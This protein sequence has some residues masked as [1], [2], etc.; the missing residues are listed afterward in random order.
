MYEVEGGVAG[1]LGNMING[2][3]SEDS[4]A[5][6]AAPK[7]SAPAV[8]SGGESVDSVGSGDSGSGSSGGGVLDL[9]GTWRKDFARFTGAIGNMSRRWI[10]MA[11]HIQDQAAEIVADLYREYIR[12]GISPENTV[13]TKILSGVHPPLAGLADHIVVIKAGAR[14]LA[15]GFGHPGRVKPAVVTWDQKW[16]KV[17]FMHDVGYAIHVTPEQRNAI[18]AAAERISG[19]PRGDSFLTDGFSSQG[20][21]L[22]PARHHSDYLKS[23][24][25]ERTL[26][27]VAQALLMGKVPSLKTSRPPSEPW[28]QDHVSADSIKSLM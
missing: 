12:R 6:S 18:F 26:G 24:E 3:G 16:M 10:T 28:T 8:S 13:L 5:P 20:I 1:R 15:H 14:G 19:V 25:H 7:A 27:L 17:A 9:G 22:V 23:P 11:P 4:P 2:G 21:W